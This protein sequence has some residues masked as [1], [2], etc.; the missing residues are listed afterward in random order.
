MED[1]T[2]YTEEEAKERNVYVFGGGFV[3]EYVVENNVRYIKTAG[4]FPSV[5]LGGTSVDYIEYVLVTVNGSNV[6]YEYK[7]AVN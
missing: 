2:K 7:R 3:N 1:K 4:V 5:T 6:T